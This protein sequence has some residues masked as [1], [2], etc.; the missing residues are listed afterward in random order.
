M[1]GPVCICNQTVTSRESEEPPN[2]TTSS[3]A[4]SPW[5]QETAGVATNGATLITM[6]RLA[7]TAA[8]IASLG[9]GCSEEPEVDCAAC[10]P[11]P[12]STLFL[13]DR[14]GD[15]ILRYD[16]VTG[17]FDDVFASGLADRIDRPSSVR[18][19]PSGHLY[20]AGF[21]R[22]DI[23]R[24]DVASG[25]MM[26]VF[27]W[28]TTLLEEPVE[29]MFRGDDLLVLGN[30]TQNAVVIDAGGMAT[31]SFGYP[32]MRAAHDFVMTPDES[33][34]FVATDTHPHF[35]SSLQVWDAAT[36]ALVRHFG[37]ASE[38]AS[39][40]SVALGGDGLLY[41]CDYERGQ[42]VRFDPATG[43]LVGTVVDATSGL[44]DAPVSIDFGPD[45]AL[46]ALDRAGIHRIDPDTGEELSLLI[47]VG[48]GHNEAPR[49]FT[50]AT[51]TAI[52]A[53][54]ARTR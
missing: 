47:A 46:Y 4:P 33:T 18:L 51:T 38:L 8:A 7:L 44:L 19:G 10:R 25:A 17:Q 11:R 41:A 30:D 20:L 22:G 53:A 27:Y 28:D 3:Q 24:F 21:G 45:G 32:D 40:T 12:P 42:I 54:I 43:A 49:S 5:R 1:T 6:V 14:G 36:G 9:S 2:V 29:L 35:G 39:A 48:D 50:F 37:S 34:V 15:S 16:G 52:A 26:D 31:R 23:V 13:T